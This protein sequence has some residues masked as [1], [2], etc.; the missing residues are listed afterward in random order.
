M[1]S[2]DAVEILFTSG[3]TSRPKGVVITHCNFIFSGYYGSWQ[4]DFHEG[5]IMLTTMPACHSNFQLAALTPVLISCATLV[6]V[7]HYSASHFWRQVRHYG[8]THIQCVSMMVRTMMLQPV[9]PDEQNHD[10]RQVL[11]Y[12]PITAQEKEAFERRFKVRV[13][14]MYGS[15]ES[16]CWALTDLPEGL[17]T[18]RRWG[19]WAFHIRRAS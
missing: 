16:I 3:T 15:T 10:V 14:N 17:A 8:A 12:L 9:E 5:D 13:M 2:E 7:K 11:Y 18:G 19:A 6:M 4:A 1:D